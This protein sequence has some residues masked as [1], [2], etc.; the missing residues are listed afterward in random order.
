M[1]AFFQALPFKY[2]WFLVLLMGL[3][4]PL[5]TA[6]TEKPG[7]FY[8]FSNFPM[9]SR[10]E[11]RTYYVYLKDTKG[12]LVPVS[13]LFGTSITNV[14]KVYDGKLSH[15][16]K[17]AGKEVKKKSD[18]SAES[19]QEAAA[20]TLRWLMSITPKDARAKVRAYGGLEL[21]QVEVEFRDG[22]IEQKDVAAGSISFKPEDLQP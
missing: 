7:E 16:K 4:I 14:K 1:T 3:V 12:G 6:R 10:F 18:L 22:K 19:R 17:S 11:P 15:L 5:L 8:P 21:H 20:A 9:Y 2:H 13:P